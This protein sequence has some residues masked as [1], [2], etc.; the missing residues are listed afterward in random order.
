MGHIYNDNLSG[1]LDRAAFK[2]GWEHDFLF[3]YGTTLQKFNGETAGSPEPRK[4]TLLL[5]SIL[6]G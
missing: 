5:S 4:K 3:S 2:D 6:A 1:E